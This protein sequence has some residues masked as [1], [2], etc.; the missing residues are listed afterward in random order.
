MTW[1]HVCSAAEVPVNTVKKFDADGVPLVVVNYGGG[2]RALP[3]VCPHMEEPLDESGVVMNCVLTCTKHLWAWNLATLAMIGETE[4]PLE[5]YD[6][7]EEN[8]DL[9]AF[10]EKELVY[11]FDSDGDDDDDFFK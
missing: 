11:A 4:K 1:K 8:G 3:P 2:Y 9:Y 7:K 10:I 5:T 6:M